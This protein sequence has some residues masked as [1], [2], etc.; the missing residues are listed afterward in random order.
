MQAQAIAAGRRRDRFAS[1]AIVYV[2]DGFG[3]P[4]A[5]AV[6]DALANVPIVVADSIPFASGERPDRRRPGTTR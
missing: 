2:D 3:R 6:T 1:V 5:D 4:L